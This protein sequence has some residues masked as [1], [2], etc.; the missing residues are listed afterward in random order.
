MRRKAGRQAGR[1]AGRNA[2][3]VGSSSGS[4]G[5]RAQVQVDECYEFGLVTRGGEQ[6]SR[7]VA[8]ELAR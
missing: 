2:A 7:H 8:S 6:K 4:K 5:M 3:R 1:Q